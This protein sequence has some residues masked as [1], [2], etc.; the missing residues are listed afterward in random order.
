M[1]NFTR[2]DVCAALPALAAVGA[3]AG[4]AAQVH[5]TESPLPQ[6]QPPATRTVP[7]QDKPSAPA[8]AAATNELAASRVFPYDQMV[9]RVSPNGAESRNM[10]HGT[11]ATG[12]TVNLHQSMQPAGAAPPALHVI[13]H[14]ELILVREGELEFH[15][16][17]ATGVVVESVG[18]G[19]LIYVAFGT[20]HFIKN[21]GTVAAKYFVVGIGGDAK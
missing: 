18:P 6:A 2:R 4:L 9:A 12:E 1:K 10:T 17:T 14:S 11:L 20:N 13:K 5:A 3:G 19:G 16:E 15:H 8:A 7:Q 21:S